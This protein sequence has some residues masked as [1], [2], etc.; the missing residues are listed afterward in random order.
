MSDQQP[1]RLPLDREALLDLARC[2]AR[3]AVDR[4]I[5]DAKSEEQKKRSA[6]P[7]NVVDQTSN[8]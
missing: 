6:E 5:E 7:Q 3:A 4:M 2:Y 1:K 8:S